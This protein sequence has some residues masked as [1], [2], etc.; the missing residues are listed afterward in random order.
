MKKLLCILLAVCLFVTPDFSVSV[1]AAEATGS[2]IIPYG[3]TRDI[4]LVLDASG[5]MRNTP[6]AKMKEA[7]L[8][9]CESVLNAEGDNKIAIVAYSTDASSTLNFTEDLYELRRSI[10]NLTASGGTNIY[11]GFEK[12]KE[13]LDSNMS[14]GRTKNIILLTD[15]LP[16]DGVS[17]PNGKYNGMGPSYS[18]P[19][20]NA[21]Y[22]YFNDILNATYNVYTLGFFHSLSGTNLTYA[23]TLL[24]DIQ[25]KGYY[26]VRNVEDI[27]FTFGDIA[28]D[29]VS[30]EDKNCPIVFVPGVMGSNLYLGSDKVWS[31]AVIDVL[32]PFSRLSDKM[33]ISK[34][35]NVH[36]YN[37][38]QDGRQNPIN[39]ALL[40]KG[41]RE[42][43]AQETYENIIDGLVDGFTDE[44]GNCTRS[45]YFFS[46][47]FRQDNAR[48]AQDL[49]TYISH[50]LQDNPGH[51][52]V[53]IVAHSM[54][55]L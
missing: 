49:S 35:L 1:F 11:A 36:N 45:I 25:N 30:D 5:S 39:Q 4:V 46:Y 16:E 31:P 38:N 54:G 6:I 7:A 42:Y 17:V 18:T 37:Y 24:S 26:E 40:A 51:T 2:T 44:N 29:I 15:G 21:L 43:G 12:A 48:S 19:Y 10:N 33:D 8:K 20:G 3:E 55:A 23:Q 22:T 47:D 9:F 13:L 41:S 14:S 50:I 53:D 34:S 27:V 28:E 52:K 32:N